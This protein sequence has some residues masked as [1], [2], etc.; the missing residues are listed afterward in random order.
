M[1]VIGITVARF[2]KDSSSGPGVCWV[3]EYF[4][5]ALIRMPELRNERF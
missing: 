1:G 2:L 5:L 3:R 4:I